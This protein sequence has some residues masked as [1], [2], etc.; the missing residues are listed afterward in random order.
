[1]SETRKQLQARDKL[2]R[3]AYYGRNG[4]SMT[5]EQRAEYKAMLD[6]IKAIRKIERGR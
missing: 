2:L 6:R 3:D 4:L 1:M 5:P